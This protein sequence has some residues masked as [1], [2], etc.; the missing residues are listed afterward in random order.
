MSKG[1]FKGR[2]SSYL[3]ELVDP[4][5]YY[6]WVNQNT[7]L[8]GLPF[9]CDRYP[10]Q[11]AILNDMSLELH[12]IKP[13]QIGLPLSLKTPV[14]TTQ[15]MKTLGDIQVGDYVYTP[16][17]NK[18]QVVYLSPIQTDSPC[19]ELTFCDGT[20]IIAD[21]NHRWFVNS[22]KAF[23][24]NGLYKKTGRIPKGSDYS[25][26]GRITTKALFNNYKALKGGK[27]TNIFYI[28]CAQ[29]M[30]TDGYKLKVDPYFLGLWLGNGSRHTGILTTSKKYVFEQNK[31]LESKG[32]KVKALKTGKGDEYQAESHSV[33]TEKGNHCFQ[34]ILK[35]YGVKEIKIKKFKPEWLLLSIEER[36]ELL[37]GLIDSDGNI[38]KLGRVEFYNTSK[39][40][41]E[42]FFQLAA[43][44]GFKPRIRVRL[45]EGLNKKATLKN[46]QEIQSKKDVYAC[47]F[48]AYS[49]TKLSHLTNKQK[50]LKSSGRKTEAF[51]RRIVNIQPVDMEPVRCIMVDDPEHQF[52][53]S[54][55]F[56]TTSNT[57]VQLRKA[58]AYV[59]RNPHRNLIY[60]MP[61]ENMRKRVYQNRVMPI[62]T[63]DEIFHDK[64]EAG[65]KPIRSIEM[66]EV[67]NSFMLM[68]PANE[69][70]ATS[71]PADVVFN[72]E[73]DLSDPQIIALFN[74]RLQGSDV[75]MNHNY[76]TPTYSG[77]GID[78]LYQN[79]DQHEYLFKCPHCGFY[80]LPKFT[81]EFIRI[82]K[83]PA[84]ANNDLSLFEP[85]W[86][87]KYGINTS[88]AYS[89]CCKCGKP[90]T[91]GDEEN[92]EWVPRHPH[93][94][95]SRGYRISPFSTRNLD[96][97]YVLTTLIKYIR[98]DNMKG[99]Q[100]T[101]LGNTH[102][103][104]DE[105]LPEGLLRTL[106]TAHFDPVYQFEGI[107]HF[108]GIDMGK[109]CHVTIGAAENVT[110][111]RT[112][113]MET[114]KAEELPYRIEKYFKDFKIVG[115]FIDRLPLMTDSDKI[116]SKTQN[117]VMPMQY[118]QGNNGA[119]LTPKT[120]EYGNLS[121]VSAHRTMHLD[122]L[123][124]AIKNGWMTF[125]GYGSQ[126]ETIIH[127]LRAMVRTLVESKE[128]TE[129]IPVW[130]KKDKNDHYF[131]SLGYMYQAVHQYYNGYSFL[132]D[133]SYNSTIYLG[134]MDN[135]MMPTQTL[136][137]RN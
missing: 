127:H 114:V 118:E 60:T 65:K 80:Q 129:K 56:I 76:S 28:D 66:T 113:F 95:N 82:P 38:S 86:L 5:S 29:P 13:S 133:Q 36:F 31:Y 68:F 103:N 84:E 47:H 18:A 126:K 45:V 90:V 96:A 52:V 6:D 101:V 14:F 48:M 37:R 102:E 64:N 73:I 33:F 26:T 85:Q 69:K 49:E 99:F 130:I 7:T 117:I 34:D 72:D 134:T 71:Q 15:G 116:R 83:L 91:Y 94:S 104:S 27:E 108:I 79:S 74:S 137:G 32:L 77:L 54:N 67:N 1:S 128:G 42:G 21:E 55:A 25:R 23:N 125:S 46:G 3:K 4:I 12:C 75:K 87:D 22:D 111:V 58:L 89:V 110:K 62:L 19:Y 105:R 135:F 63:Q 136:F 24:L 20:K 97:A 132:P 112:A 57:E 98:G 35:E 100:N 43:S 39:D 61:D 123:V 11:K 109:V 115:G 10:F 41:T 122:L 50:N 16:K 92:H 53:C 93:R 44:L 81:T 78:A 70:A 119:M 2:M 8:Q 59:A 9:T 51:R 131:H 30:Q 124:S 107:P 120:D 17:G 121:Y 88:E 40:L 106:F